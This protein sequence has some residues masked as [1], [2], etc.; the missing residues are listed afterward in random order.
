MNMNMYK[1]AIQI[2]NRFLKIFFVLRFSMT[3][4]KTLLHIYLQIEIFEGKN[5][6]HK[7][8][9]SINAASFKISNNLLKSKYL[10]VR[11]QIKCTQ[12]CK[13]QVKNVKLQVKW[14][15]ARCVHAEKEDQYRDLVCIAVYCLFFFVLVAYF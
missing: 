3:N 5:S 7:S 12:I 10:Y 14:A 6:N 15:M 1:R 2:A 13:I 4:K 8:K 9:R 11:Q